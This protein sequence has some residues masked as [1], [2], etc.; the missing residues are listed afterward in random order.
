MEQSQIKF[1]RHMNRELFVCKPSWNHSCYGQDDQG[2]MLDSQCMLLCCTK[3]IARLGCKLV[4]SSC[5]QNGTTDI[6]LYI[7]QYD[8][9]SLLSLATTHAYVKML[10]AGK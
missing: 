2:N 4:Q 9:V 5:L 10:Q 1:K 6:G 3:S 7:Q 8:K